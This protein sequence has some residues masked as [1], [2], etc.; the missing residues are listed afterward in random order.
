MSFS[1]VPVADDVTQYDVVKYDS[2]LS[3]WVV[4]NDNTDQ[5]I[6]VVN[7]APFD[8]SGQRVALVYWGGLTSAIADESIVNQGGFIG[9]RDGRVYVESV[10]RYGIVQPIA[11]D[12]TAINA[13]DLVNIHLR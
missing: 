7:E 8:N 4:C 12:Q 6:G 9:V 1:T 2:A 3:K 5:L 13:G 11:Y 10:N